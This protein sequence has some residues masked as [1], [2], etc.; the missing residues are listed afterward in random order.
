ME[1]YQPSNGT[2]GMQFEA[3]FCDKCW[4]DYRYRKAIKCGKYNSK[5]C[6]ILTMALATSIG[7]PDYPKE[8]IEAINGP[9]CTAYLSIEEGLEKESAKKIADKRKR[10]EKAGQLKLFID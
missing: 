10:Q 4:H 9:K 2:E 5:A 3:E 1:L 6:S 8:W 7:D